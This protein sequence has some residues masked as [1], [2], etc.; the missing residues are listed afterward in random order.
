[1]IVQFL[2]SEMSIEA[3]NLKD[4]CHSHSLLVFQDIDAASVAIFR[5]WIERII[6]QYNTA[7]IYNE[8]HRNKT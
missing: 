8:R 3:C 6:L 1:M 2:G 7:Y 4:I 5:H